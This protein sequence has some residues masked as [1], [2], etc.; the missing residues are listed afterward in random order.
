[1]QQHKTSVPTPRIGNDSSF[2]GNCNYG[3]SE[4]PKVL[5]FKTPLVVTKPGQEWGGG[6]KLG[7]PLKAECMIPWPCRWSSPS[8]MA[9][10]VWTISCMSVMNQPPAQ[11]SAEITKRAR[12][13]IHSM[14]RCRWKD[15][16]GGGDGGGDEDDGGGGGDEDDEDAPHRHGRNVRRECTW[17]QEDSFRIISALVKLS[18]FNCDVKMT[19][20]FMVSMLKMPSEMNDHDGTLMSAKGKFMFRHE[21]SLIEYSS[22]HSHPA[23]PNMDNLLAWISIPL[24]QNSWTIHRAVFCWEK[25]IVCT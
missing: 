3:A 23:G 6:S 1:M 9:W 18:T 14:P 2:E 8:A 17:I 16:D 7:L 24:S 12:G 5:R 21:G 10:R 13:Y 22:A 20:K 25:N 4:G 15:D 19:Q 11:I